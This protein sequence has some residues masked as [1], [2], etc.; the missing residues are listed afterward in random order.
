MMYLEQQYIS[1]DGEADEMGNHDKG[2][3]QIQSNFYKSQGGIP[4]I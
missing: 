3:C 1:H 2:L 4:A